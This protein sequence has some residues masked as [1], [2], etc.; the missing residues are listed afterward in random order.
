MREIRTIVLV[1]LALGLCVG[2]AYG[3]EEKKLGWKDTAEFSLVATDGNSE[4]ASLGFKNTLARQREKST[5][6]LRVGG[7]RVETTTFDRTAVNGLVTETKTSET[8]AENYYANGR[9]NRNISDTLFWYAGGGWERN[10]P[11]GIKNRYV[12]EGGVGNVWRDDDDL[13]F[14]TTY[15]ATYT[16]QKDVVPNPAVDETYLGGC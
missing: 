7:V 3:D 14:K 9:Y 16:I 12:A 10:E 15:G 8:T 11:S 13:K 1:I 5:V 4:S 2:S 6:T